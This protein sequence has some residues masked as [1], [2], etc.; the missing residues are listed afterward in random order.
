MEIHR[1]KY[2]PEADSTDFEDSDVYVMIA[3]EDCP[4][5]HRHI[6][7]LDELVPSKFTL[8]KTKETDI[9]IEYY[10]M[11]HKHQGFINTKHVKK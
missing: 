3:M 2:R 4:Y 5:S 7:T 1:T 9:T 6:V 8:K 10:K 11:M